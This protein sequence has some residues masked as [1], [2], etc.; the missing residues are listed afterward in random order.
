MWTPIC[1]V[2]S[3]AWNKQAKCRLCRSMEKFLWTL[4]PVVYVYNVT[5]ALYCAINNHFC[6]TIQVSFATSRLACRSERFTTNRVCMKTCTHIY[7]ARTCEDK[8]L[9]TVNGRRKDFFQ[10]GTLRDFSK[11]FLGGP[12]VVKFDFSHSKLRNNLFCWNCQNPGAQGP[13]PTPMLIYMWCMRI[14]G[15]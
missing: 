15:N 12:N 3:A 4:M 6:I 11:I 9:Y 10:G 2:S 1:I 7:V 13:L 14:F 5:S 8:T